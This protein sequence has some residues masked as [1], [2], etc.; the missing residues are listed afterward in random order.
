MLIDV[1]T[2]LTVTKHPHAQ[3]V[4]LMRRHCGVARY[5]AMLDDLE[6]RVHD[7]EVATSS[8]MPPREDWRTTAYAPLAEIANGNWGISG[9]LF[10]CLVFAHFMGRAERWGFGRYMRNGSPINGVTYFLLK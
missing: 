3:N 9:K 8:W 6:Q 2:G 4:A 5:R 7:K 10:G 1:T